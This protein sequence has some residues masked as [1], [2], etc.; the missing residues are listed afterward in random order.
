[1]RAHFDEEERAINNKASDQIT[2]SFDL[3][4]HSDDQKQKM[5]VEQGIKMLAFRGDVLV[6]QCKTLTSKSRDQRRGS[7]VSFCSLTFDPNTQSF[8]NKDHTKYPLHRDSAAETDIVHC[9]SVLDVRQRRKVPCVLLRLCKKRTS[10][11]KYVLYSINTPTETKLHVEFVLP[12]EIRDNI[13]ILQGPTLVWRHEVTVCFIS[14]Q[15]PG[16]KEIPVP[17]TVSFIGEL[18]L[19]QRKLVVLGAHNVSKKSPDEPFNVTGLKNTLYFIDDDRSLNGDCL[20]PDAYSCVIQYM[21]VLSAE[22]LDGSLRS[23]VLAVTNMKQLVYFEN[24]VPLDV[25]LLPYE[26]P[27]SIQTLHTVRNDCLIIITFSQ[28]N[29]CAVWKDT[30]QVGSCWTDVRLILVDDFL[31]CGTD[32]MLLV[33]EESMSSGELLS[34]FLLTDLCAITYSCVQSNTEMLNTSETLQENYLLTVRALE[35]R[36]Q[37]GLNF[38]EDLQRDVNVKERLLHQTLVALTDLISDREHVMISPEQE[39]LVS[40]WDEDDDDKEVNVTDERMQTECGEALMKV[41]RVWQRVIGESLICGVVMTTTNNTSLKNLSAS[42]IADCPV[43]VNSRILTQ[44]CLTSD[45]TVCRD[46]PPV[47]NIRRSDW[48]ADDVTS[49]FTL[50]TV[51]DLPPLLTSASIRHPII[52]HYCSETSSPDKPARV[53]YHCGQVSV[54]I[55]DIAIG[56]LNPQLL[57]DR[58]RNTDD[59]RED[60]F[61]LMAV[62]DSWSFII[63]CCDH[64]LVDV[65]GWLLDVMHAECLEVEPHYATPPSALLLFHWTQ[66]TP[67][68]GLLTVHCRDELHLLQ[69]LNSLCDFL[70]VS[71]HV[72]LVRTPRSRRHTG[73][74]SQ[75]LETEIQSITQEVL[76]VLQCEEREMKRGERSSS[77]AS[78]EPLQI[79]REEWQIEREKYNKRLR[80]LVD[81]TR[82]CRLIERWIHTQMNSD[83]V[84]L[85]ETRVD[86]PPL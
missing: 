81:A 7:E 67:F 83:V 69:F 45:M 25:C 22:D 80:P 64:T 36:L 57:Q 18:P 34:N 14:S 68:Q 52:L 39:G 42:I 66:K 26:N 70:P 76:S 28:K 61:S 8:S 74:L 16:V 3:L 6:F 31:G 44:H 13:S 5:A 86:L 82:Y 41:N 53:S 58:K 59:A 47:K 51:T 20:V 33:F 29:V 54:D 60:L 63:D 4:K 19:C 35:S 73:G 21:T 84:A 15:A 37:S 62:M 11:F 55:K 77:D 78:S 75:T 56:K 32:Q 23:A 1:M 27:L 79:L 30:F 24:G 71:H 43:S 10:A 12:Y 72:R 9:S 65:Q 17:M 46:P 38:L 48:T 85:M 50:L 2:H 40:L 49:T